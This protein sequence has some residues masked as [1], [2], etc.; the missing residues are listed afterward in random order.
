[1]YLTYVRSALE[2]SAVVWHSSLSARNRRDLERVQKAALRV[3]LQ[4]NYTSYKSGLRQLNLQTLN[5]RRDK[6]CLKFAKKC[7]KNDKVR[8]LFP[9]NKSKHRIKKRKGNLFKTNKT[10]TQR[11]NIKK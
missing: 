2:Q 4:N 7:L 6:L 5:K 3:I 1:M 8:D 11:Y 9:K 10:N